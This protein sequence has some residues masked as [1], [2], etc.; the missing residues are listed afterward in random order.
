MGIC[1]GHNESLIVNAKKFWP[2]ILKTGTRGY[3]AY[4]LPE[5]TCHI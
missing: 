2:L 4:W 1:N 3:H 5:D